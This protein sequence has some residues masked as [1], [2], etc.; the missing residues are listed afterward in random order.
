M[1]V[2]GLV[3]AGEHKNAERLAHNITAPG[4]RAQA[5]TGLVEALAVAGKHKRAARLAGLTSSATHG[6]SDPDD[7][8]QAVLTLAETL[9]AIDQPS[10]YGAMVM[11]LLVEVLTTDSWTEALALVARISPTDLQRLMVPSPT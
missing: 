4:S 6:I 8:A 3:S 11:R 5:M 9:Y 10:R 2:E 1:L 7:C